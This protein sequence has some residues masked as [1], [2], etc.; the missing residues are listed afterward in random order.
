RVPPHAAGRGVTV[1][2]SDGLGIRAPEEELAA[3]LRTGLVLW[4]APL[5]A[6]E[7]AP[8]FAGE[9]LLRSRER[10]PEW[11]GSL[12]ARALADYRARLERYQEGIRRRIARHGG[13]F[14]SLAAEAPLA[15]W[16]ALIRGPRGLLR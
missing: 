4:L 9:V 14:L 12:D 10:E 15:E 1:V 7:R 2:I 5:S 6:S 8:R 3:L 11:R 13:V 16:I